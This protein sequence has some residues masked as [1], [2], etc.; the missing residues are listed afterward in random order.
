MCP[1]VTCE[2]LLRLTFSSVVSQHL[3][4]SLRADDPP[5]QPQH[6]SQYSHEQ[7]TTVL[8]VLTLVKSRPSPEVSQSKSACH[9]VTTEGLSFAQTLRTPLLLLLKSLHCI[10]SSQEQQIAYKHCC[11]QFLH[12]VRRSKSRW[13]SCAALIIRT[14]RDTRESILEEKSTLQCCQRRKN[15]SLFSTTTTTT[16]LHI[17]PPIGSLKVQKSPNPGAH[18]HQ[19]TQGSKIFSLPFSSSHKDNGEPRSSSRESSYVLSTCSD[20]VQISKHSKDHSLLF[21]SA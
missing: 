3:W 15:I 20:V 1:A 13:V 19:V 7:T 2:S 17:L 14:Q 12:Q 4:R 18:K 21:L 9:Q 11:K 6:N 10:H 16:H 5:A 8:H